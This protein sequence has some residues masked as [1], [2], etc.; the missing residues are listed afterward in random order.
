[1]PR[2]TPCA[3]RTAGMRLL[4]NAPLAVRTQTPRTS[5]SAALVLHI[6]LPLALQG[7]PLSSA[8]QDIDPTT[9]EPAPG[10]LIASAPFHSPLHSFGRYFSRWA[11]LPLAY[12]FDT[13]RLECAP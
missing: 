7:S 4:P 11:W 5:A 1:G 8:R 12:R 10:S 6:L 13:Q 9:S 3:P 2:F